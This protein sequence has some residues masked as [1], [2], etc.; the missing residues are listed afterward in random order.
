MVYVRQKAIPSWKKEWVAEF[1]ELVK[2]YRTIMI[3]G[4]EG[5]SAPVLH[6]IRSLIKSRNGV[7][8]V[9]K[10]TL[11]SRVIDNVKDKCRNIEKLKEHLRG[12]NALILTN[13]NPFSLKLFLDKN[14]VPREA[15]AGDIAPKNIVVYSGNTN[16]APGPILSLFNKLNVPTS[17]KEGS[18][19]VTKDTVVVKKGEVISQDVAELL[20]RLDIKPIEVGLNVKVAYVDGIIINAEDLELDLEDY[21]SRI[22]ES[23]RNAIN[24]AVNAAFPTSESIKVIIGKCYNEAINLSVNAVIPLPETLNMIITKA[25]VIAKTIADR[26]GLK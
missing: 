5:V 18:I 9:I 17:I 26:A 4:I 16:M 13:D 23:V 24:L 6:E 10:N 8:K 19:W 22:A 25:Q 20:R 21:R 14:K 3:V 2:K 11:F 1:T 12:S 15:R 7:L